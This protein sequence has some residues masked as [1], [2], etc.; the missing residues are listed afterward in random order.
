MPFIPLVT[1]A[2]YAVIPV[3]GFLNHLLRCLAFHGRNKAPHLRLLGDEDLPRV[4]VFITCAGEDIDT[5]RNT[6]AAACA[7]DYPTQF[8]RVIVLD[9]GGSEVLSEAVHKMLNREK[10]LVYTARVKGKDHHFKAGNLNHGLNLVRS[11]P[12]GPG[13]YVAALDADMIPDP[14]FLRA[15]LPHLLRNPKSA[16]AQLPQVCLS[17]DTVISY[18]NRFMAADAW[19]AL[20]RCTFR[21]SVTTRSRYKL[22]SHRASEGDDGEHMVRGLWLHPP[23]AGPRFDWWVSHRLCGRRYVLQ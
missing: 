13:E 15:L 1:R 20:L 21:G 16:L 5:V 3:P 2:K 7:L 23:P 9:D 4:D 6:I 17:N 19:K 18:I 14:Q 22:Q 8:F 11:L 10:N 12:D